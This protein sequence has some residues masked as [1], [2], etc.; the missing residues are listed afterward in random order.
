MISQRE[1]VRTLDGI[2]NVIELG[3]EAVFSCIKVDDAV[4]GIEEYR[5]AGMWSVGLSVSGNEFGKTWEEY[6][7]M[8]EDT[9]SQLKQQAADKLLPQELIMLLIL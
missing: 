9:V 4:P 3:V 6:Q 8:P 5:N 2:A 7:S 1:G